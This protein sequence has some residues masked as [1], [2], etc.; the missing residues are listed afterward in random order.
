MVGVLD[1]LLRYREKEK[2]DHSPSRA[3]YTLHSKRFGRLHTLQLCLS[4]HSQRVQWLL[5]TN[6]CLVTVL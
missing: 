4:A 6:N 3:A 1:L 2:G 5:P